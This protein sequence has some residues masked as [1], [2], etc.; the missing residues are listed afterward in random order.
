MMNNEFNEQEKLLRHTSY[1]LNSIIKGLDE[2]DFETRQKIMEACGEAC[3]H[4]DRSPEIAKRIAEEVTEDDKI[5]A[6]VNEE[7][8][9]CGTWT[10]RGNTIQST[11]TECGC[12]LVRNKIVDLSETFCYCSRGWVKKIFETVLKRP[13]TVELEKAIGRG[14]RVCKFVI[15][16]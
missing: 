5:L 14:E 15:Y 6:R 10:R 12:P 9:W 13:V 1:L 3:A 4:V 11:C 7:I 16:M 8:L 2:L